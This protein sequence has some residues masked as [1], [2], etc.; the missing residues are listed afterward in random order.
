M[1]KIKPLA[2][3]EDVELNKVNNGTVNTDSLNLNGVN[4]VYLKL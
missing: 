2:P 3:V 1:S 4:L